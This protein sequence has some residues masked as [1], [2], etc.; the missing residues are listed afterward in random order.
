MTSQMSLSARSSSQPV[1]DLTEAS[2]ASDVESQGSSA[3]KSQDISTPRRPWLG[4]A[5][6]ACHE[7]TIA[8]R[9]AHNL[10]ILP[11]KSHH[12]KEVAQ[13][14]KT[15]GFDRLLENLQVAVHQYQN[16]MERSL[17]PTRAIRL[18]C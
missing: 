17:P 9:N 13:R 1:V 3:P 15:R 11:W 14:L 16:E 18:W 6:R 10:H 4:T 5:G 8:V 12:W 2:I 7:E